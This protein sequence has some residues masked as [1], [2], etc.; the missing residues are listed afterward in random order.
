MARGENLSQT[1]Q[2]LIDRGTEGTHW[3]FKLQHHANN[4]DLIHDV[5]CLAN[6]EHRGS[7]FLI[8]GVDDS[9]YAVIS[10]SNSPGRKNQANFSDLFRAN[11]SKFFQSRTPTFY[12]T[13]IQ[14]SGQLM[15]VLVIEDKPHKPYYLVDEYRDRGSLVRAHH[16]YTRF[17]DT[18]TPMQQAAPPHEIERMWR[19][20]FGLDRS[21][22]ERVMRY[23]EKPD[24]WVWVSE[25]VFGEGYFHHGTFPEF[26][27]RIGETDTP[28]VAACNEEWTRGEIRMD[29]N[30]AWFYLFYYHQTLLGRTRVVTFDDGK[31][32]M[33]APDWRPRCKGRFY[34][35][36]ADSVDYAL[37]RFH[38]TERR[39]DHSTKLR[40]RGQGQDSEDARALWSEG[41]KIPVLENYELKA[42]LG[43]E[44][45]VDPSTDDA[46]QY[47]LFLRNQLEFEEWR[48][49][50]ATS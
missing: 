15:D 27:L 11:A 1:I 35:Y 32:S 5:L 50:Q 14:L 30:S 23:L 29:N 40:I 20:R 18:N 7:R 12:L 41:L 6:A 26:T 21:P 39:L 13:E 36:T 9:S 8:F 42:F 38:S 16:V 47:Q 25:D 37:Q 45:G 10:V 17:N 48:D 24:A 43:P 33:V 2:D 31:K 44:R 28:E 46:E 34:F 22:I 49:E 3:D 19:E 4:A